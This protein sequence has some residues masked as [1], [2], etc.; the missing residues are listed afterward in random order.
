MDP[1]LIAQLLVQFGLPLT[2]Q[3]FTWVQSGKTEVTPADFELLV[4]LGK[5]RSAD[6]LTAAGIKIEGDKVVP[7]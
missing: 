5:Y 2:Q 3:I 4:T 7:L 6:S 1:I